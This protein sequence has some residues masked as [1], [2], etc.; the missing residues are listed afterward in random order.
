MDSRKTCEKRKYFRP[1]DLI[2]AAVVLL[3]ALCGVLY[4]LGGDG[5]KLVAVVRVD[6]EIYKEIDLA[7][8][9]SP[10]DLAVATAEGDVVIHIESDGVFVKSS[11]CDDKLCVNTGKLT[12]SSQAS[13]C[14][15][16]KVS[17]KLVSADSS[18]DTNQ[19]D[20]IAG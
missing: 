12:K 13:V 11:P 17:V 4:L 15:P 10:Y 7:Q 19:P 20:A 6:G 16:Q 8:V 2:V 18:P 1:A 14:L 5:E 9:G 3:V